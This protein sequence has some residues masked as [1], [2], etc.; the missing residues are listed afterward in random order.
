M[1]TERAP[2]ERRT[3]RTQTSSPPRRPRTLRGADGWRAVKE[4]ALHRYF[5]ALAVAASG[6]Y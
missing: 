5:A 6:R 3:W 4:R 1:I 2:P